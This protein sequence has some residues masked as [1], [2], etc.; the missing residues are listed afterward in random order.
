MPSDRYQAEKVAVS[1]P[2]TPFSVSLT[3]GGSV[4][5]STMQT[6]SDV[7]SAAGTRPLDTAPTTAKKNYSQR[8]SE[9]FALLM[10]NKLRTADPIFRDILPSAD[11]RGQ[12]SRSVSGANKKLKKTDVRYST[13]DGG[14]ELLASIKTLNFKNSKIDRKSRQLVV[15]RY[16]KN[17]VRNDHEL[18]AEAMEH[19][20][21][22]PYAVL[23]AIF[24]IPADSCDDGV[25]EIS[26]FAHAI[27]TFR[28][29]AGRV[30]PTDPRELFERFFIGLYDH[31]GPDAGEIAFYDVTTARPPKRGRPSSLLS[32]DEMISETVKSF[33]VRNRRYIEWAEDEKAATPALEAT[34]EELDPEEDESEDEA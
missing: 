16:T 15:G 13:R 30:Y 28:P 20:E 18:R 24:L 19:H 17:M 33:G 34:P 27:L 9:G 31:S 26:S 1:D 29:R 2:V 25:Q 14:L 6:F 5:E 10:A 3:L 12:E 23:A 8:L 21:R 11:G 7:L 4:R 22:F 32:L